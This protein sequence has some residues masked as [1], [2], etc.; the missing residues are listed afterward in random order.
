MMKVQACGVIKELNPQEYNRECLA[1]V[2][3]W[4]L[5]LVLLNILIDLERF[6]IIKKNIPK[7]EP[8]NSISSP[9]E[10]Q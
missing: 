1:T 8:L 4:E 9:K 3:S 5:Q 2:G 10:T 7:M 6:L